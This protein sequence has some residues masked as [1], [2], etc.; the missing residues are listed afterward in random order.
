VDAGVF[1]VQTQVDVVERVGE[2]TTEPNTAQ[3]TKHKAERAGELAVSALSTVVQISAISDAE[4]YQIVTEYLSRLIADS[5]L[6]ERFA[7]WA[8]HLAGR[9]HTDRE[10]E[11]HGP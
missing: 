11:F 3:D 10:F 6:R 7:A 8:Q 4:T 2:L 5:P 1:V 9:D